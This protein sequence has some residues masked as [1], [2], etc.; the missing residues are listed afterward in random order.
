MGFA[1]T[2]VLALA[3]AFGVAAPLNAAVTPSLQDPVKARLV[4]ET[5]SIAPGETVWVALRLEMRPGW[6]VYWRN[7]GDAGLP[8]EIAWKLP[9]GFTAGEIAWPIPERFVVDKIGNYGY[10]GAVDLLIPVT[11]P[12][13]PQTSDPQTSRPMPEDAAPP[14]IPISAHATWLVCSDICIPGEADLA[15]TLPVTAGPVAP[16]PANAALFAAARARLPQP[17]RFAT[18]MAASGT[19][20]KLSVP[21]A[22]LAG[23]SNPTV[24]FFPHEPNIIDA[25]AE[26]RT[27]TSSDG[28]DLLLKR[29]SGPAAVTRLPPSVDGVLVLRARDGT[30]RGYAISAPVI[31]AAA[32]AESV[33]AGSEPVAGWWQALLLAFLGGAILNLMPCVF[34]ILS[35]KLLGIAVS[36]QRAEER[37]HGLAYA[38]GVVISFAALGGLLLALRAGG[39]AIG[40]GFQLQSPVVVALLAYLLFA[41][42]LSLSGVVEFGLGLGGIGRSFAER[43]GLAGAFATGILA[44]IVATPCTAPF[45][46]TALGYAMLAAPGQALAVFVALGAGLAAPV[47]LATAV[48]GIAR[49]L[50]RPGP[51]ILW[52]K[53]L[54][55]FPLYATVAWLVWVLMQQ[56]APEDGFFALLGL[57]LIGFA[58]WMYGRTRLTAQPAG[59]RFGLG[60][61]AT[62]FA[63]SLAVAA[64]LAPADAPAASGSRDTG[65]LAYES[66]GAARLDR[67]VAD[68]T[69]VF[70]NL[71]AAWCITC[72][73]NERTLD[74]AAVRRAFAA[75]DIV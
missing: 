16:D 28:L 42:G 12:T 25:A 34:P 71:T 10:G 65:G 9:P 45:M 72:L 46:G 23:I 58:A 38:A 21:E 49:L 57:V 8:P 7:P 24:S 39:A 2:L 69:P 31:A 40:W 47:V 48:P 68:R 33:A 62:V 26:P 51:W 75:R 13:A 64:T 52:F 19:D 55:A 70:I 6:H 67:L 54:L 30:E 22:A 27:R 37:R 4:A 29:A 3:V 50:P 32:A 11:A 1:G 15:L 56:V 44:T 14:G 41:M 35:L 59:R 66:F 63:A 20:L 36:A 74:S 53:Q 61:A 73:V 18:R 60:L 17:A 5:R 43:T